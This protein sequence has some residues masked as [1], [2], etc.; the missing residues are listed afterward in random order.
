MSILPSWR[1]QGLGTILLDAMINWTRLNPCIEKMTL[2]V[3]STNLHAIELYKKFG[4]QEEGRNVRGLKYC[5]GSY[6]DF[7]FMGLDVRS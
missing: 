2:R 7:I 5:D 4:F 1:N 3:I 6:A